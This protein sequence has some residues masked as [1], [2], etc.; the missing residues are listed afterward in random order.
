MR[1]NGIRR[2]ISIVLFM[3]RLLFSSIFIAIY[4]PMLS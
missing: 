3:M 1:I 4:A 2:M